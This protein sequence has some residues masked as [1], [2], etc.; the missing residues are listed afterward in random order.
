MHI[1]KHHIPLQLLILVQNITRLITTVF[2]L[3][4]SVTQIVSNQMVPFKK[5]WPKSIFLEWMIINPKM[6]TVFRRRAK[7]HLTK[8]F[9]NQIQNWGLQ[10]EMI[11]NSTKKCKTMMVW[12]WMNRQQLKLKLSILYLFSRMITMVK[13]EIVRN[14]LVIF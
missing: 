5:W 7:S 9:Q 2:I 8:Y 1:C 3:T 10:L 14:L 11:N 12:I 4:N 13:N 6:S